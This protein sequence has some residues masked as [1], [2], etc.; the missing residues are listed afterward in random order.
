MLCYRNMR[1]QYY[2]DFIA[3]VKEAGEKMLE[4]KNELMQNF[5]NLCALMI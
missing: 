4:E 3:C 2:E 5:L 1:Q